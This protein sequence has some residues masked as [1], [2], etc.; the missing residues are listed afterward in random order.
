MLNRRH[1]AVVLLAPAL[2]FAVGCAVYDDK[3]ILPTIGSVPRSFT[4]P[5]QS[6][7]AEPVSQ[8]GTLASVPMPPMAATP[9][10]AAGA[11]APPT[12]PRR[13][14]TDED[15]GPQPRAGADAP[16]MSASVDLCPNDPLK[17]APGLCGCSLPDADTPAAASCSGLLASLIH[18]YPFDGSGNVVRD[19]RALADG[20]IQ[21][22]ALRGQGSLELQDSSTRQYLTLP[23][24]LLS[25]LKDVSIELWV[26]SER[27]RSSETLF[28]LT[29]FA[30]DLTDSRHRFGPLPPIS[31]SALL[32][33]TQLGML[34]AAVLVPGQP[35]VAVSSAQAL[36]LG[37][38]THIVVV[39]DG[40]QKRL[41]LYVDG[42]STGEAPLNASLSQ[43]HDTNNWIGSSPAAPDVTF[44]GAFYELRI[45]D[46][47]LTAMQIATSWSAGPDPE[48]LRDAAP[49]TP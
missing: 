5:A 25:Q 36:T 17:L 43:V 37:R 11:I 42:K 32:L 39:F 14:L 49:K 1:G 4:Q 21:G 6:T 33:N 8:A 12:L 2:Q 38:V 44:T 22:A 34:R 28:D 23:A 26:Q 45:Y 9:P 19:V 15:A 16:A 29:D 40:A 13:P 30:S 46:T 3:L 27:E 7:P 48:F 24:G 20:V 35:E 41:S 47:A 10:G 31:R 18:R